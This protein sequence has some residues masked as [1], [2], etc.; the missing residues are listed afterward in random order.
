LGLAAWLASWSGASAELSVLRAEKLRATDSAIGQAIR[1]KNLP[2]GV[3]WLESRGATYHRAYGRRAVVPEVEAMT[4]DTIFDVASLTKVLATAPAVMMLVERGQL[5]LESPVRRYLP[6]FGVLGKETVTLHHLLTHTS[7]LPAGLSR[8]VP[9]SGSAKAIELA[10]A[11]PLLTSPG[12]LFRYSDINFI[13]LAELVRRVS[14]MP[15]E[16]F[17]HR[18]LFV[19]LRMPDTEFLPPASKLGRIAP[20]E[21]VNGVVLRGKVHDPTARMMGGVAGHAGLFSTASDMAR[22]ARMVLNQGELDGFRVLSAKTVRQMTT[23]QTPLSV[24]AQRG[25]GW[26][27]DSPYAGPR[28]EWFLIGSFGHT[29]WTGGSIW[30]DPASR[31]FVIFLSNRNHPTGGNVVPLRKRLGTLAAEAVGLGG[32]TPP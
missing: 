9:W 18:E 23:V 19:P 26:D 11:E 28:G 14:G 5:D 2:G 25:L 15:F 13:V 20:T 1:E 29:G 27:I 4:E 16:E 32:T 12:A 10:C 30:I 17:V 3:L 22:F 21:V 8:D 24:K 7:G 6:E 31:T